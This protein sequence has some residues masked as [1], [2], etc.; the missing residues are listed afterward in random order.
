MKIVIINGSPRANGA[1]GKILRE[2]ERQLCTHDDVSVEYVDISQM[3]IKHCVG[4][5][6]CYKTGKCHI[7]DDAERLSGLIASA[8]ALIMGSPT[9]ASNLSGQL[10]NFI[11]RGHFVMEQLLYKMHGISVATGLNY[12]SSDACKV[13]SKLM[14]YSGAYL[15][16]SI[17]CNTPFGTDPCGEK[18]KSRIAK[19]SKKLYIDIKGEKSYPLQKL[20]HGVIFSFGIKPFVKKNASDY[21]G[22]M[23]K[24]KGIDITV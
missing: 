20:V 16:G 17:V 19:L 13:I 8:D 10:K 6:S 12:G 11:D 21:K 5:M 4:C 22:T 14:K 1:T 24:W 23:D 7:E 18:M 2:F 9:Y 15:T 3:Q